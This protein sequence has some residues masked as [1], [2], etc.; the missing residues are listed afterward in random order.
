MA[1]VIAV[2]ARDAKLEPKITG[3]CQLVPAIGSPEKDKPLVKSYQQNEDAM[4]L[5]KEDMHKYIGKWLQVENNG[6]LLMRI[7]SRLPARLDFA[8]FYS[9]WIRH[10][11]RGSSSSLSSNMWHGSN[12]RRC[13]HL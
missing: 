5:P 2:L 7:D 6:R 13:V 11:A 3:L 10:I 9:I 12:A 1:A 8:P 4:L